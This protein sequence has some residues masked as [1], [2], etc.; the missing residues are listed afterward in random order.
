MKD[1]GKYKVLI[2]WD[3]GKAIKSIDDGGIGFG[4]CCD[5]N[6][7]VVGVIT[8]GDFRRGVLNGCRLNDPVNKIV[9]SNFI[10][11]EYGFNGSDV[12]NN[13]NNYNIR[14]IP[15]LKNGSLIDIISR[16]E[17]SGLPKKKVSTKQLIKNKVVIMAG[18]FG[19]RLDPFTR[20]LPKPLIPI[21]DDPVI[22]I[23]MDKFHEYGIEEFYITL[24]HKARMVKAYFHDHD[25]SYKI[26][27][28]QEN[29][30]LGTAGALKLLEGRFSE[31][32][33]IT[34]CDIIIDCDYKEL[35][36][37]HKNNIF[38]FFLENVGL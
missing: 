36:N 3:I 29:A 20:I 32:F 2:N 27:Y 18:G 10:F 37:F 14:H 26:N 34:N 4:V 28:A 23:I 22:K 11:I 25:L 15:V 17:F 12:N 30:P 6:D 19:T 33:F 31:S 1:I 21:G 35:V 16:H 9:N 24:N 38:F 5:L 7:K 8:D 13:F